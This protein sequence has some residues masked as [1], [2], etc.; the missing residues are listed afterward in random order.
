MK[1][2]RSTGQRQV[3]EFVAAAGG[4]RID[5]LD[6]EREVEHHF[7]GVAILAPVSGTP[8]H[9]RVMLTSPSDRIELH[10]MG[11]DTDGDGSTWLVTS[12]NLA[13][14][15]HVRLVSADGQ[16]LAAGTIRSE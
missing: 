8:G 1:V 6:L 16:T 14:Y 4:N 3:R 5:V 9:V 13:R 11:F 15:D 12:S 10:P 2:A 7:G